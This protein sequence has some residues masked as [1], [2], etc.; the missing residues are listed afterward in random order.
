MS[1]TITADDRSWA[2]QA[3][4]D[5][6][7]EPDRA[8]ERSAIEAKSFEEA[9]SAVALAARGSARRVGGLHRPRLSISALPGGLSVYMEGRRGRIPW[10]D[11]TRAAIERGQDIPIQQSLMNGGV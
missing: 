11:V 3:F 5:L 4:L 2:I 10:E 6:V 9:V 8:V 7:A 1:N